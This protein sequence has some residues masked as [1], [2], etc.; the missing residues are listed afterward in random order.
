VIC[1]L[2]FLALHGGEYVEN[3]D[4]ILYFHKF[5]LVLVTIEHY[6]AFQEAQR[7]LR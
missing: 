3:L 4:F 5:I 6:V 2:G 7:G 1:N